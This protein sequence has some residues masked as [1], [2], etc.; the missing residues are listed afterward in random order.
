MLDRC[1]D[2]FDFCWCE[3]LNG[4]LCVLG[5][6]QSFGGILREPFS[7]NAES[8]QGPQGLQLLARGRPSVGPGLAERRGALHVVIRNEV[9]AFVGGEL[10]QDQWRDNKR[11]ANLFPPVVSFHQ[12][13]RPTAATILTPTSVVMKTNV[14]RVNQAILALVE[15]CLGHIIITFRSHW[16]LR[17]A[18]S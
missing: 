2:L 7:I 1:Q 9:E 15:I 16:E 4:G 18:G 12:A 14:S 3:G 13:L 10:L 8:E 17:G 6:L 11:R 5:H